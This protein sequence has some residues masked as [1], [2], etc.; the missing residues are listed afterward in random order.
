MSAKRDRGEECVC[1]ARRG[2]KGGVTLLELLVV[3]AILGVVIA[4][5]AA[6]L[7]SGIRVWDEARSFKAVEGDAVFV[8]SLMEKDLRNAFRFSDVP[9]KGDGGSVS[10][11]GLVQSADGSGL[12]GARIG[13]I[14]YSRSGGREGNLYRSETEYPGSEERREKIAAGA[15]GLALRYA[16]A[17]TNAQA[18]AIDW[19]DSWDSA[20]NLPGRVSI[21]LSFLRDGK[22]PLTFVRDVTLPLGRR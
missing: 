14:G 13:T 22:E 5:I 4:V 1:R 12:P 18:R 19:A 10:F 7:G 15:A 3:T 8:L 20:T 6:C 2:G 21:E 17:G 16:A 9:F 11:A